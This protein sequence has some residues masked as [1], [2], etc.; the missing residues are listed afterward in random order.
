MRHNSPFK[1]FAGWPRAARYSILLAVCCLTALPPALAN[2]GA[3]ARW[4]PLATV[5]SEPV[6]QDDQLPNSAI[7]TAIANDAQGF[8]WIGTQNGLARWDGQR[9]RIF[10]SNAGPGA[11]PDSQIECLLTD[12]EG[13][14]WIGT[15]SGGLALYDRGTGAYRIYTAGPG[16]LSHAAVHAL[17][18]APGGRLWVGTEAGLD[19]LDPVTGRVVQEVAAGGASAQAGKALAEGVYALAQDRAGDLWIGTH[20]GLVRR[21]HRDGSFALVPLAGA[22]DAP[23]NA[24]MLA[25][26]GRLWVGAE[27]RG[28]FVLDPANRRSRAVP[29][30][31]A[32]ALTGAAVMAGAGKA[33]GMRVRALLEPKPGVVWLGTYDDGVIAVD[34]NSLAS[35]RVR[36]GASNV[37]YGDQNIRALHRM[38]DGLVF[39]AGN[40]AI[41]RYDP[42]G[43]AFASVLGGLTP[44]A[45]LTGRNAVSIFEAPDHRI[46]VSQMTRGVD[47]I[48]ADAQRL[49]H[50][51]PSPGG[52]PK[53]NI[54]SY[55]VLADRSLLLGTD[56][57]LFHS[58]L[59]ARQVRRLDQPGRL[60]DARAQALLRD[61]SR[62]W[63]G[64]RDGLWGYRLGQDGRLT[65]DVNVPTERLSDRR[66]DSLAL[67]RQGD[68][69]IATDNGLNR[70]DPRTGAVRRIRAA[71]GDR[72][73]PR[74]FISSL[75]I[76]RRGRLWA[77]TF[78]E[79]LFMTTP[80]PWGQTPTFLRVSAA[81]GLPNDNVNQTLEDDHG[82]MWAS[83][84]NGLAR[85]DPQ[86]RQATTFRA[87]EGVAITNFFYNSGAR[88]SHGELLFGG[89]DG[90]ALVRPDLVRPQAILAPLVV[91]EVREGGRPLPGDPFF[92]LARDKALAVPPGQGALEVHFAALDYAAPDRMRYAY[93]LQR[94][95][96]LLRAQ[97]AWVEADARA[98]VAA[99][100][101]MAPG[102]YR[103]EIRAFDPDGGASAR[104]VDLPI[105]VLP[106][107]WQTIWFNLLEAVAVLGVVLLLIWWRTA[108][109]HRRRQ[110]LEQQV[111]ERTRDLAQARARAEDLARTTTDF[112]ANMS[113]EIRTPLNGVV[114]VADLLARS[115]LNPKERQMA[116]IIR[117]SGD[118]LQRLLSDILD[119][120]RIESGKI[121]IENAP[122]Q[123]GDMV[124]A[125]AGL[126]QLKCDEKGV[127][128][129]INVAPEIDESVMGDLARV[130]QILTNLLSNAV[131]FTETGEIRLTAE[132]TPD[133][134]ARFSV[135]DTGIGFAAAEKTKVLG[136]FEQADSSITRRYGGTGLG[137]SICRDLAVLMGG[138]LDCESAPGK[139]SRFWLDLPLAP[140][141]IPGPDVVAQ[142]AGGADFSEAPP[143]RILVAD[144]HPTNRKVVQLM[145]EACEAELTEVE[146]GAEALEAFRGGGYDLILMDMQMPV[147][148]GLA[149]VAAIRRLEAH[150]ARP[151]TPIIMLTANALPEHVVKA[152]A[153]GADLHLAKPLTSA[154]LFEALN[155]VMTIDGAET[156]AA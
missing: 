70:Y 33:V 29:G 88:T 153:A 57:G 69:W 146:N 40:S 147:M 151:R 125:V 104:S 50:L 154:A 133:G 61:G 71:S 60:P 148:D 48:D 136:R 65:Q 150:E 126:W 79:G 14:F 85:I 122:F 73:T 75:T 84:D 137:L 98:R 4:E 59:D 7:P 52:L 19:W 41:T 141:N 80:G 45:V 99:F 46:W 114:A 13:R 39:I 95:D 152:R 77:S 18:D 120:A 94:I 5:L 108:Y 142:A 56:A 115:D 135:A 35:R 103:L 78:G 96:G 138:E 34:P 49:A 74:G 64:G 53:A 116:E 63:L 155:A 38:P 20:G 17:A 25:S 72:T 93:R 102:R 113:H 2:A 83:T 3:P 145:L 127:G 111:E 66:I 42:R 129:Q 140:V 87:P 134:G 68:L 58:S 55:A 32:Q 10:N 16:G 119:A 11:L 128:L 47:L 92:G 21:D 24:L 91:T 118:T 139:G 143:L 117:A 130:R 132:R 86:A 131:K 9:F 82:N 36:L 28:A 109:L 30:S 62:L 81:Q 90:V 15:A 107:W 51:D 31:K 22:L 44:T 76:D 100:T 124:R 97:A 105:Q 156:A 123:A 27:S 37:L 8:V 6:A 106:A 112:L 101:N 110:E 121:S 26:D 12:R 149:A 43:Q 89:R 23:I 67:D 1:C 144:D 54:R